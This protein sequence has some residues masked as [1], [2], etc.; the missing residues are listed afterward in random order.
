[1]DAQLRGGQWRG[2]QV[3]WPVRGWLRDVRIERRGDELLDERVRPQLR[4]MLD[5][6]AGHLRGGRHDRVD[7]ALAAG[8]LED[9]AEDACGHRVASLDRRGGQQQLAHQGAARRQVAQR[10]QLQVLLRRAVVASG[11]RDSGEQD[12]ARYG[13]EP[14]GQRGGGVQV[15][16]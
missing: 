7:E 3:T 1:Q 12:R 15:A 16:E 8:R 2:R 13:G 5:Q 4:R 9:T 14:G 10:R 11:K 6:V